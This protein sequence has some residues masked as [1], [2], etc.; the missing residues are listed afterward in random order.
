[1]LEDQVRIQK[2]RCYQKQYY[3]DNKDVL[4]ERMKSYFLKNKE[5]LNEKNKQYYYD[6]KDSLLN[7]RKMY[8]ENNREK[9]RTIARDSYYRK[10]Q[11]KI[12]YEPKTIYF[13]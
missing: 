9:I 6:N 1:M 11:I 12:S 7:S 2:R 5:R 10:K 13:S 3:N 4:K 8:Y